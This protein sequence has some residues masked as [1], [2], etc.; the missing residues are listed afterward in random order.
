M[1]NTTDVFRKIGDTSDTVYIELGSGLYAPLSLQY[2]DQC[3]AATRESI[4]ELAQT[5]SFTASSWIERGE[6]ELYTV[7]N[8]KKQEPTVDTWFGMTEGDMIDELVER[9]L[10]SMSVRELMVAA[11]QHLSAEYDCAA[12]SEVRAEYQ[13][14]F[15]EAI[16]L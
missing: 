2:F 12:P 1:K 10:E 5:D 8:P 16:S 7:L 9:R 13:D 14:T 15:G 4:H 6:L 3:N 11:R